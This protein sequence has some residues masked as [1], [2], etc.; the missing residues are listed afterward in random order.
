M[1]A[2]IKPDYARA[3]GFLE[4]DDVQAGNSVSLATRNQVLPGDKTDADD[5]VM[6]VDE[7]ASGLDILTSSGEERVTVASSFGLDKAKEEPKQEKVELKDETKIEADNI[8]HKIERQQDQFQKLQ[9]AQF[10]E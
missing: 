2:E 3:F 5:G 9:V 4:D 10:F 1:A 6:D 8:L 7:R